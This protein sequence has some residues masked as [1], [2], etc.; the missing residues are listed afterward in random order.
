MINIV[1]F[2]SKIVFLKNS[3]SQ[4]DPFFKIIFVI[5]FLLKFIPTV[6]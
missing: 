3:K 6:S 1:L 2:L 4:L 5:S